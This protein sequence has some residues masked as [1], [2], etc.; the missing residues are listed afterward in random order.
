MS[1]A[2]CSLPNCSESLSICMSVTSFARITFEIASFRSSRS[3]V[4]SGGCSMKSQTKQDVN[5]SKDHQ[6]T[7]RKKN[8]EK[9]WRFFAE[10]SCRQAFS[11][12]CN[13]QSCSNVLSATLWRILG[14][15]CWCA[16]VTSILMFVNSFTGE[17][18]GTIITISHGC[19]VLGR[20]EATNILDS[21]LSRDHAQI[22]VEEDGRCW[23]KPVGNNQVHNFAYKYFW[24]DQLGFDDWFI[25]FLSGFCE[26]KTNNC[27]SQFWAYR[28]RQIVICQKSLHVS[29]GID[30]Y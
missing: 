21:R 3:F 17:A 6:L 18:K 23:V 29:F 16:R 30:W 22:S 9:S 8:A 1:S 24:I 20:G 7:E 27:N 10:S 4:G 11:F 15:A 2:K 14:M 19:K 28:R 13:A 26:R 5:L 25:L 12:F